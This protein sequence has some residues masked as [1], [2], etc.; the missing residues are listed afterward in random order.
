MLIFQK[1]LIRIRKISLNFPFWYFGTFTKKNTI[2]DDIL[3]KTSKYWNKDNKVR[4]NCYEVQNSKNI[5]FLSKS[6]L[7]IISSYIRYVKY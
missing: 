6:I 2:V 7:I 3:N 4:F 5:E 1:L